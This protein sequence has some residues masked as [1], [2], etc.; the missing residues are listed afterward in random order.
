MK[1]P[2]IIAAHNEEARIGRL[3]QRLPSD[4]YDPILVIN[5]TTDSTADIARSVGVDP[6]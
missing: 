3:L 1:Y 2:V 5:G 6:F 4:I